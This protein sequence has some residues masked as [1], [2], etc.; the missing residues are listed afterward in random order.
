MPLFAPSVLHQ[1][2]LISA[3]V[4]NMFCLSG[5]RFSLQIHDT[6]FF[7]SCSQQHFFALSFALSLKKSDKAFNFYFAVLHSFLLLS[8][9][10][11]TLFRHQ[12]QTLPLSLTKSTLARSI[13]S[14]PS[15]L[16]VIAGEECSQKSFPSLFLLSF[17]C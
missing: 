11:V 7:S 13:R 5:A 6:S 12:E 2:T 10:I 4:N 8:S 9:T 15:V 17:L 16:L 1:P 14:S 3:P